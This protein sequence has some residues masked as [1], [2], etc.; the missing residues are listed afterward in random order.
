[1]PADPD[2]K[3]NDNRVR[4]FMRCGD[5][6]R[7]CQRRFRAP[8]R[9][10]QQVVLRDNGGGIMQQAVEIADEFYKRVEQIK[11]DIEARGLTNGNV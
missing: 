8:G 6:K 5:S 1:M 3:G 11:K 7:A 9:R 4:A 2:A 10:F